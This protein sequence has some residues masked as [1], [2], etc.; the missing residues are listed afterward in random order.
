MRKPMSMITLTLTLAMVLTL[1]AMPAMAMENVD[2][3]DPGN[4]G[5]A[6]SVEEVQVVGSSATESDNINRSKDSAFVPPAFGS[7]TS[8]TPSTG[9]PLTPNISGV[10]P[11]PNGY[12]VASGGSSYINIVRGSTIYPNSPDPSTTYTPSTKFTVPDGMYYS[13]NSIGTLKIPSLRLSVKV[14]EEESLENL[15]KGAGHFKSTSCWD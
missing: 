11:N 7:P 1:T 13:D 8:N 12:T 9:E 6:S 4:F 14:F 5:K 10:A 15:K 3:A 2:G